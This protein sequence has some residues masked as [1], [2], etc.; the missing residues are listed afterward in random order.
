MSQNF[1]E[2]L[3]EIYGTA[4]GN[5]EKSFRQREFFKKTKK[6]NREYR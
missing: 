3:E 1:E 5:D 2:R 4:L 6:H